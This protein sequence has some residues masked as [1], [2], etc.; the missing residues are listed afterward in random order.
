MTALMALLYTCG[1]LL[2]LSR[3]VCWLQVTIEF[4]IIADPTREIAVK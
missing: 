4:P 1:A 2:F 3:D